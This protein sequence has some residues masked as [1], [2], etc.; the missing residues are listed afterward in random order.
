MKNLK[1]GILACGAVLL[2]LLL[3][4][5]FLDFLKEDKIN[6]ILMVL[7]FGFPTGLA[8]LGLVRPPFQQWQGVA[9]LAG[10][11]LAVV[12]MRLWEA[13]RDMWSD[14][15]GKI[16]LIALVLGVVLSALSIAKPEERAT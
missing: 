9:S 12:K 8:I 2:V 6:A 13:F 15:E 10:F 1:L 5:D 4:H 14:T 11:L 7:A 16:T 3:K